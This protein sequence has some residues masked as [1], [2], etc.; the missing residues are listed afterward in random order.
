MS[1]NLTNARELPNYCVLG[2]FFGDM[3]QKLL[4]NYL[5]VCISRD[6]TADVGL[7]KDVRSFL[8]GRKLIRDDQFSEPES[9]SEDDQK[10]E[11]GAVLYVGPETPDSDA[12]NSPDDG[13]CKTV[14]VSGWSFDRTEVSDDAVRVAFQR[15]AEVPLNG[16][17][18][19]T[20]LAGDQL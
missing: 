20:T 15:I 18:A 19:T 1:P 10:E 8:G 6:L 12:A 16:L 3:I 11:F 9:E 4:E 13:K 5:K 2:G 17:A 7:V 14:A